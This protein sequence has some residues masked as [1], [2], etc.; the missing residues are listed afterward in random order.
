M[1]DLNHVRRY[2]VACGYTDLRRRFDGLL[3]IVTRRYGC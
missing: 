1:I 3:A 2:Y